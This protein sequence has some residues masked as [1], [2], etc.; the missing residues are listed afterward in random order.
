MFKRIKSI[1][2]IQSI[3]SLIDESA[4]IKISKYNKSLQKLLNLNL[5]DYRRLS[6]KYI[7]YE[8]S[9]KNIGKEYDCKYNDLKY[10]GEYSN[11]KR[12]GKGKEYIHHHSELIVKFEGEY[13]NG[14]R[15]GKGKE[16][17]HYEKLIKFEG[18][19]LNNKKW[20]GKGYDKK[21]KII[22]E[23]KN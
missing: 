16:Y 21:G 22:F 10:E 23:I 5:L 17:Y 11:G 1:Y 14:K 4:K 18:E 20:N 2:F 7:I 6:G 15:N 8:K 3:F 13:L 19:Y 9:P 12:N